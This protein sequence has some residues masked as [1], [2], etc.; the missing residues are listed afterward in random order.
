MHFPIHL[1]QINS[2]L[3]IYSHYIAESEAFK[4]QTRALFVIIISRIQNM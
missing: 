3:A 2:T 1:D 4:L